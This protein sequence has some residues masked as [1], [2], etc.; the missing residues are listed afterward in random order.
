MQARRELEYLED[1]LDEDF[2]SIADVC[3]HLPHVLYLV[4]RE[5]LVPAYLTKEEFEEEVHTENEYHILDNLLGVVKRY[6][7]WREFEEVASEVKRLH[8]RAISFEQPVSAGEVKKTLKAVHEL[9]DEVERCSPGRR[10]TDQK[11]SAK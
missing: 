4:A 3:S 8:L 6:L 7:N 11:D 2:F 9:I 10:S 5:R 1:I